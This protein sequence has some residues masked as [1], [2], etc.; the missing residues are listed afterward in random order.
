MSEPEGPE[1][2]LVRGENPHNSASQG[3]DA[4]TSYVVGDVHVDP[5][6]NCVQVG[7]TVTHVEPR[8]MAVL[9]CLVR[10]AG[11][12]VGRDDLLNAGWGD[13]GV[14]DESLTETIS[15][16]RRALGDSPRAPRFIRTVPKKGY[17]LIAQ[18]RPH[19]ARGARAEAG[20]LPL[21]SFPPAALAPPRRQLLAWAAAAF[22]VIWAGGNFLADDFGGS[23]AAAPIVD[24]DPN[25]SWSDIDPDFH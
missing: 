13:R 5:T 12:T 19:E 14:S 7:D 15:R 4:N 18:V 21:A 9:A 3:V 6:I 20:V 25:L 17:R 2:N 1:E 16:L 24:P 10:R 11:E 22:A 8:H 23:V